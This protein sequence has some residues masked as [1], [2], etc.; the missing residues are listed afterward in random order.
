[1]M[2]ISNQKDFI[3]Y[4]P[5]Q[6]ERI[7]KCYFNSF[8]ITNMISVHDW[9]PSWFIRAQKEEG[10]LVCGNDHDDSWACGGRCETLVGY[11]LIRVYESTWTL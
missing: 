5:E 1:M 9:V 3:L 11:I 7:P 2:F 4:S 10:G 6:E 8:N